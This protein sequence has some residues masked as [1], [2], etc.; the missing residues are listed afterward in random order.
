MKILRYFLTTILYIIVAVSF[1]IL[2]I[3]VSINY[4]FNTPEK[5]KQ[6]IEGEVVNYISDPV[7]N[8]VIVALLINTK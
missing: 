3:L 1:W 8:Q 7:Q 5:A 4:A 2:T 6:Y